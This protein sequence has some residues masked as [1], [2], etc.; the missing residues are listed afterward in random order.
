MWDWLNDLLSSAVQ[1]FRDFFTGAFD[2][3]LYV[4]DQLVIATIW[5]IAL[6]IEELLTLFGADPVTSN[7]VADAIS[8]ETS[9]GILIPGFR[10]LASII[11]PFFPT[12]LFIAALSLRIYIWLFAMVVRLLLWLKGHFWS[13]SQ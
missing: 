9:G 8:S 5:L 13:S 10:L 6:L 1:W 2:I 7:K 12:N 4:A 3:F 11:D